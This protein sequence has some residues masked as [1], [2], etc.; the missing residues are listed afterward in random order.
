MNARL[1]R[2][3]E[4]AQSLDGDWDDQADAWWRVTEL[5]SDVGALTLGRESALRM[6]EAYRRADQPAR[7]L[8]A[9]R[10]ALGLALSDSA[11]GLLKTY[12]LAALVDSGDLIQAEDRADALLD[13][14]VDSKIRPM[15]LDTVS[16]LYVATGRVKAL[17][18]LIQEMAEFKGP[19]AFGALFRRAQADAL[20]GDADGAMHGFE[21]CIDGLQSVSGSQGAIA[22]AHGELGGLLRWVGKSE[23]ALVHFDEAARLW[24]QAAR[25][26]G[27]FGVEADRVR[28]VLATGGDYMPTALDR[29]I[30]FC[31]ERGL[32]LVEAQLRLARGLCRYKAGQDG[33]REDLSQ[34]IAMPL[35]CG[36]RLQ[37]GR[38]R[39]AAAPFSGQEQA[40]LA[41]AYRE[42]GVDNLAK[43]RIEARLAALPKA[44]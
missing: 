33:A 8:D 16:G 35:D 42:L 39:M 27:R 22:A 25:R 9:V 11:Q 15:A 29:P 34:A 32:V 13:A 7:V 31:G 17:R 30:A 3:L 2:L 36:A 38:A 5:A 12:R 6:V 4:R 43:K 44:H 10:L 18:E 28:A 1:Q 19:M 14:V 41:R 21:V 24:E 23:E 37:A 26:A 40:E 20:D